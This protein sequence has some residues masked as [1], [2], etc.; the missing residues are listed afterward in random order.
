MATTDTFNNEDRANLAI[1]AV[2]TFRLDAEL[3]GEEDTDVVGDLIVDL[4]HLLDRIGGKGADKAL[5]SALSCYREEIAEDGMCA[6]TGTTA[7]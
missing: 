5:K 2:N 6:R 4:L 7:A 3:H 1:S